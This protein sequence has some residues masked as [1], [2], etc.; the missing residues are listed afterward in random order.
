LVVRV[1]VLA[2]ASYTAT[3]ELAGSLFVHAVQFAV[4]AAALYLPSGHLTHHLSPLAGF[5]LPAGQLTHLASA[6]C[7]P[8][9]RTLGSMPT[10][11][12]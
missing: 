4:D 7:V 2:H 10:R 8:S 1:A 3:P 5:C 6:V 9:H 12:E 11:H